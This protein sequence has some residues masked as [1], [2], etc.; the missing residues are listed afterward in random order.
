M[1]IGTYSINVIIYNVS[2]YIRNYIFILQYIY[3]LT[4]KGHEKNAR[5]LLSPLLISVPVISIL[6]FLSYAF[7]VTLYNELLIKY[8]SIEL[9]KDI[10]K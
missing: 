3:K 10:N 1:N 7:H 6:L 9:Y 4:R 8:F 2:M 5:M